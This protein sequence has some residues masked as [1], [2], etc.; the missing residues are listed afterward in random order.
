MIKCKTKLN[1]QTEQ[2]LEE[3]FIPIIYWQ[4]GGHFLLVDHNSMDGWHAS[5]IK[6]A[7]YDDSTLHE[8]TTKEFINL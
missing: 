6:G 1:P 4:P 2:Y 3:Q 5:I 7:E 8:L